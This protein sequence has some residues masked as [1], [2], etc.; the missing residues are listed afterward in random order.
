MSAVKGREAIDRDV[1]VDCDVVVVGSGA[2][3]AVAAAEFAEG[4]LSVVL[5]EEGHHYR[6]EDFRF[7]PGHA[8][9]TMYRDAAASMTIGTV[10]VMYQEGRV[11]GG[12][13]VLNGGMSWPTPEKILRRWEAEDRLPEISPEAMAPHFERVER[14]ISARP[15]DPE[16]L[17]RDTLLYS[18]AAKRLGYETIDNIRNQVHCAGSNNCAWGCPT[19][20]KRSMLLTY[21]PRALARGASCFT[22]CRVERITRRGHR[23]TG[24]VGRFLAANGRPTHRLTVRARLVVAAGGAAQTPALLW[25]SG[26]RSESGQLGRNLTLHPNGKLIGIFA[27]D[28]SGWKG[29]HQGHQVREFMDEGI[30]TTAVN[31]PPSVVAMTTPYHGAR[32]ADL[33]A[34]YNKMVIAGILVE[35]STTGHVKVGPGGRPF[36][37]YEVTDF[38]VARIRRG[39]SLAAGILFEAGARKVLL[40]F[41]HAPELT[42]ADQI[43]RLMEI[44]IARREMEIFTVHLMSTCR[45]S[46]DPKLGVLDEW[47]IFRGAAGLMVSDAS[48]LPGPIGV[49]PMETI[50]ALATR[51]ARHVLEDARTLL[52]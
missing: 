6:T 26:F 8:I 42:S 25:R 4:G 39:L 47:G 49:N 15:Q 40:P 11:L 2:G 31:V 38:D 17:G 20:A 22:D 34:E 24:V 27:E 41:K 44:P 1:H 51:N 46:A 9:R 5:I 43:P 50:C 21:V 3:G 30:L 52:G 23:A 16:S 35:D 37:F 13:T 19:G 48:M 10:P 14:L 32:L 12:S 28:V 45:M 7:R 18:E 29:V 36:L 33:L